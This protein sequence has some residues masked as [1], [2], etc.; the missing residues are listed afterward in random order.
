M[1]DQENPITLSEIRAQ[2]LDPETPIHHINRLLFDL[3]YNF[4]QAEQ[5]RRLWESER[6][7]SQDK[8]EAWQ[9]CADL[10]ARTDDLVQCNPVYLLLGD[11]R[12]RV[13]QLENILHCILSSLA[14]YPL[15]YPDP[16]T[17]AVVSDIRQHLTTLVHLDLPSYGAA[18]ADLEKHLQS[19]ETILHDLCP[20]QADTEDDDDDDA[21]RLSNLLAAADPNP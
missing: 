8:L 4:V 13:A 19:A 18:L 10:Q 1:S 5:L 12:E 14:P 20:E 7:L 17:P 6:S 3:G 15:H 21:Q 9:R 16:I 2:Y 11:I